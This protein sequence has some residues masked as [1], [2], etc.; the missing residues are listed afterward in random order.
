MNRSLTNDTALLNVHA[1]IDNDS[2]SKYMHLVHSIINMN[3][4]LTL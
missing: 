2:Q 3:N 4:G 1:T